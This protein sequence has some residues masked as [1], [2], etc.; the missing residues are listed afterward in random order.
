[1][2]RFV[3]CL[4][5]SLFALAAGATPS[6]A[7]YYG[8]QP[9]YEALR[10]FDDVVL[11]PG[12]VEQ[13]PAG[14]RTHWL[15]YVSVGEVHPGRDYAK[16][17]PP[18]WIV[19]RNQ[20]WQADIIDQSQPDWP[21]FFV[22]EVAAP[23]WARGFRGFFLDTLDSYQLTSH[24]D[25][26]RAAQRRGLVRVV[27]LLKQRFPEARLIANRGFELLPEIAP[28]IDVVAAESLYQGW[29]QPGQRYREVPQ[30]DRDWLA[31]QLKTARDTYKLPVLAIDY[32]DPAQRGLARQTA[33]RIKADGFIPWVSNPA[34]DLVG[35]GAIEVQPRRILMLYDR[36]GSVGLRLHEAVRN[37]TMPLHHLGYAV[38]Y[39]NVYEP[40]PAYPL[41]GR[42]AGIVVWTSGPTNT[43]L[44][45]WLARQIS[46]GMR[47]AVLN[48]F[49]F[50][51]DDQLLAP[52]GLESVATPDSTGPIQLAYQAPG[53]GFEFP[54]TP[55]RD[56]LYPVRL[57][58]AGKRLLQL[59]ARGALVD[60]VALTDW[61]GFALAP[62]AVTEL[63]A[64]SQSRWIVN[65]LDFYREAL[66]LPLLPAPDV[67]TENGRR[68]MMVHVDGDGFPSKAEMPGYPY[69]G[70]VML[71]Q[72][73]EKYRV[74]SSVSII[75]GELAPWGLY[76]AESPAL[77]NIARAIFALPHVEPASHTW[78]HPFKWSKL[79]SGEAEIGEGN[80]LP[81]KGYEFDLEREIAGS[82]DYIN[83]RLAPKDKPAH[84]LFWSGDCNPTREAL[85]VAAQ[86]DVLTLNGGDTI[87]TRSRKSWSAIEGLGVWKGPY[88]QVFAPNQ[89]ENVYTGLWTGPFYGYERVIETFELTDKPI[90][91]KP[92]DIYYH[93]YAASKG[94]SLKALQKVY[95]W[96][97]AQPVMN[98]YASEYI[99]KVQDFDRA[100]VAQTEDGLAI[101]SG[102]SLREL[103]LPA[104]AG[105]PDLVASRGIAGFKREGEALYLHLSGD[106]ALLKLSATPPTQPYLSEANG[107][108]TRFERDGSNV[109]ATLQGHLPLQ[110]ALGNVAGCRISADG[111]P[112]QPARTAGN[113]SQF[114]LT[115]HAV[116]TLELR[117]PA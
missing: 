45:R 79:E 2:L 5:A 104:S 68:L 91:F 38:D 46:Q 76:P 112:L 78:S 70:E 88:F 92:I 41:A 16:R 33:N 93:T 31:A 47:V 60:A 110:F 32:V 21:A 53:I 8:Q 42:Y 117:C 95:E 59:N 107:R 85:Q 75:E 48:H 71:K 113:I 100:S 56:L 44:P 63:P 35:V 11:E 72:L 109:K 52:F 105:F 82:L 83:T 22:N 14:E 26:A 17:L 7:L 73:L 40:L 103:R 43:E 87:I 111:K 106:S 74:P 13:L 57:S 12:H 98:I 1:M 27:Q 29:D 62:F 80:S 20:A 101:R 37:A 3:V 39:A 84:L 86:H 25:A 64:A 97:L 89:N 30:A 94:A 24:D 54:P 115:T 50:D 10:A 34:L 66:R 90:R 67:T 19:G 18:A 61:G 28:L 114:K 9:P 96:A 108:L 4:L 49:G 116:D 51:P 6:I 77:E 69:A 55:N 23:L 15:A 36:R 65:P 81:L 102:P 99:G 58:G